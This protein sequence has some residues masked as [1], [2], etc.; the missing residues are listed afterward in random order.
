MALMKV[1]NLI[2]IYKSG[3]EGIRALGGINLEFNRNEFIAVLGPSGCGKSTL[4]NVI[5]GLEVPSSGE[6]IIQGQST[7][8]FNKHSWDIYRRHN[9]DLSFNILI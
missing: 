1:K 2:K 7:R 3:Y 5:S 4:L 8:S 9:V 6:I